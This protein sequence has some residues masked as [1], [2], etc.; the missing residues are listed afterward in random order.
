MEFEPQSDLN[1][2]Q[3]RVGKNI[4]SHE[5]Q[6]DLDA[7][8]VQSLVLRASRHIS[9]RIRNYFLKTPN[10]SNPP[11]SVFLSFT[12][13][14]S[15]E[16]RP[17]T[18]GI[19]SCRCMNKTGAGAFCQLSS[20][21]ALIHWG[22]LHRTGCSLHATSSEHVFHISSSLFRPNPKLAIGMDLTSYGC[23]K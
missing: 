23:M 14:A 17:V 8:H 13:F 18:L 16:A 9:V 4:A 21:P 3:S 20:L 22:K 5:Y 10:P 12:V 2:A 19:L 11:R 1:L 6:T 7:L 15:I